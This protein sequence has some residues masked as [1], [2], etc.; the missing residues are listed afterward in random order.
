LD[1]IAELDLN[2]QVKLLRVLQER[3]APRI[4]G[5]KNIKFDVRLITATHK[6]LGEEVKNGNFRKDL[7]YRIAGLPID[8][9]PLRERGNDILV[10]SKYFVDKFSA[11]N[12]I[13]APVL[14]S[15]SKE[16]LMKYNYPGNVR[17]LKSIIDLACVMS[18]GNEIT[19]ADITFNTLISDE[20]FTAI[21]KTLKEY[22]ADIIQFFLKK[23]DN[24]IMKV[25]DKLDIGKSTIYNMIKAGEVKND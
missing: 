1:E 4:G 18:N 20:Q 3:E 24:N 17:E 9:P 11:D 13:N 12:N 2:M 14:T 6:N 15:E 25:A 10:L 16:I 8:L 23:Y 21:E 7:Y 19:A 22:N 5:D